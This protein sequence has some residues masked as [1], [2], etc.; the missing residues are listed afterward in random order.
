ML[1]NACAEATSVT[2]GKF[3]LLYPVG[4]RLLGRAATRPAPLLVCREGDLERRSLSPV[5]GGPEGPGAQELLTRLTGLP[6]SIRSG[7]WKAVTVLLSFLPSFCPQR[8]F[9]PD[10]QVHSDFA[11]SY[12]SATGH[13][14]CSYYSGTL[15]WGMSTCRLLRAGGVFIPFLPSLVCSER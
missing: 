1:T 4:A 5:C 9:L 8:F 7:V 2:K 14:L 15:G 10:T 13:Q 12:F 11:D 3:H 6:A